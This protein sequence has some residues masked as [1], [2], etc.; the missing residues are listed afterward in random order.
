MNIKDYLDINPLVAQALS[1]GRPV[2][3]LESTIIS[4]GMPYPQNV[5][6][7]RAVETII[8]AEGAVPA[9]IAI[10]EGKMKAGLTDAELERLGQ[11]GPQ[12]QKTSHRDIPYLL[13]SG[14][15]GATTVA[16]TSFIASLAG[17][18]V[19]CTGGIGGVHRGV[20]E[21]WDISSDLT[22]LERTPVAVVCAGCKAILDC[23]KTLEVLETDSVEVIGYR[24]SCLPAFY[25]SRSDLPVN[26]RCDSPEEIAR[27]LA[28][29]WT[30]DPA[31]GVLIT[32]PVPREEELD[33]AEMNAAIDEALSEMKA[34][35]ITGNKTTPYLL[36]K[37]S[38]L[39]KGDSLAANIALVKNNAHLAARIAKAFAAIK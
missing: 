31:G 17:I 23:A 29:K 22:E 21:T 36:A 27:L 15:D 14:K 7:A 5:E 8:R 4:H 30:I 39:T 2:V 12:A 11:E 38:A 18:R 25:T 19:F 24:T 9:T 6:T 33:P 37:V 16:A 3:A 35:G 20:S 10:L 34:A 28:V 26:H 13:A 1:E 32:N